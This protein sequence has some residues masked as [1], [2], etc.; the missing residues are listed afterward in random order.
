[1]FWFHLACIVDKFEGI[2]GGGHDFFGGKELAFTEVGGRIDGVGQC[3]DAEFFEEVNAVDGFGFGFEY[4]GG[5][6]GRVEGGL[7]DGHGELLVALP[8]GDIHWFVIHGDN[9]AR[10]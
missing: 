3:G 4:D 1:M 10:G 7:G 5:T 9:V 8:N 2:G 6:S